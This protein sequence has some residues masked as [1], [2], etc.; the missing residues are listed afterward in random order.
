[1][2]TSHHKQHRDL[3]TPNILVNSLS[4]ECK[5]ADFGISLNSGN[6]NQP[7]LP[8]YTS[9]V[10]PECKNNLR[11]F[12]KKGDIYVSYCFFFEWYD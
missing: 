10:P 11:L 5:I 12:T 7:I 3:R 2:L 4:L 8:M 1:M 9:L 6:E